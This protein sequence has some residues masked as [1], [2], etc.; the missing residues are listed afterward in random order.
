IHVRS[1]VASLLY[2]DGF[3]ITLASTA[4]LIGAALDEARSS[5]RALAKSE[6]AYRRLTAG[7]SDGIMLSSAEGRLL[8]VNPRT[9][10]LTGYRRDELIG[11]LDTDVIDPVD[12]AQRPSRRAEFRIAE[13]TLIERRFRRKNGTLLDVE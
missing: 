13:P 8:D 7:A 3:C 9:C 12:L 1:P 11:R 6:A 2:A 5:M 4:L 10:E